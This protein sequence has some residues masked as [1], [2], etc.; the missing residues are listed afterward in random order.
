MNLDMQNI[1]S[2]RHAILL[3][4]A[5]AGAV[6]AATLEQGVFDTFNS[7]RLYDHCLD[8]SAWLPSND[9]HL[10]Y[11]N[12][13][14]R[15]CL[16]LAVTNSGNHV[17]IR[18]QW[19]TVPRDAAAF[20]QMELEFYAPAL[21]SPYPVDI[22]VK[23]NR[24]GN[25][26]KASVSVSATGW[27]TLSLPLD[28][29]KSGGLSLYWISVGGGLAD[30]GNPQLPTGSTFI[31]YF[32]E[33]R[34][35]RTDETRI[36][37]TF[38]HGA[39]WPRNVGNWAVCPY[40][41]TD[42]GDTV[43]WAN[44]PRN[45][46]G[47]MPDKPNDNGLIL[48][49]NAA[50]GTMSYAQ[51]A[52][53]TDMDLDLTS[54]TDVSFDCF[55]SGSRVP[56]SLVFYDQ[57]A[58]EGQRYA[59]TGWSNPAAMYERMQLAFPLPKAS[60]GSFNW[61][62]VD[63]IY[64]RVNTTNPYM[65]GCAWFDNLAFY[66]NSVSSLSSVGFE[67][68]GSHADGAVAHVALSLP[69]ACEYRLAERPNLLQHG[70]QGYTGPV[71]QQWTWLSPTGP[72]ELY[73]FARDSAGTLFRTSITATIEYGMLDESFKDFY[74]YFT[75]P[76]AS[77]GY[78]PYSFYPGGTHCNT[79]E[80]G[81]WA[82]SH[83]LAYDQQ[84]T[85]SPTWN[86]VR[87][88]VRGCLNQLIAWQ[89]AGLMD[90]TR[91]QYYQW[92]DA[93]GK[94]NRSTEL[95]SI[96]NAL[97]AATLLT[98]RG[99]CEQ[100]PFLKDAAMITGMCHRILQPMDYSIYYSDVTHRFSWVPNTG[101]I[102]NYSG[103]NRI[104]NAISR[105]LAVEYGTWNFTD[106]EF[107]NSVNTG[108]VQHKRSYDGVTVTATCYDGSLFTYLLP[109]Q[110]LRETETDYGWNSIDTALECQVRVMNNENRHAFGVSD[111]HGPPPN[112]RYTR[113]V[114][115]RA[116]NNP[117]I[118]PDDGVVVPGSILMS[119]ITRYRTA[120]AESLQYILTNTPQIVSSLTGYKASVSTITSALSDLY[121]EL[122][123][124][125]AMLALANINRETTWNAFFASPSVV[126]VFTA[127][128]EQVY[129]DIAPPVV[130]YDPPAAEYYEP[131]TVTLNAYDSE[132][133][134]GITNVYYTLDGTSPLTSSTRLTYT[135]PFTVDESK[136]V[137]ITAVDFAGNETEPVDAAYTI[138]PE[139]GSILTP[140]VPAMLLL[141][142][143]NR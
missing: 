84:R 88:K 64:F 12:Y 11:T 53:G 91:G 134:S 61:A 80:I 18:T 85:W 118:D 89:E 26:Q 133:G 132:T 125:H 100:R 72:A 109:A 69:G 1:T 78:L 13:D 86:E 87:A 130:W 143:Y 20:D 94:T 117:Y 139:P 124:G 32:D 82:L 62:D 107:R 123:D 111:S 122:D 41:W 51:L 28:Y 14:G 2:F 113:G 46:W 34:L 98:I 129:Q 70:W 49:Y 3:L 54:I 126:N 50:A 56:V 97:L 121:S 110:F 24:D 131:V 43:D 135:A 59:A 105:M 76:L 138:I 19:F 60:S 99:Y 33:L 77:S 93:V 141:R 40:E 44:M 112:R 65:N 52:P 7:M 119:C 66:T 103:E 73:L 45:A 79:T 63:N 75:Y 101:G 136:T 57:D 15:S 120:A 108:L 92:Y 68:A 47:A 9:R 22:I 58:P 17:F 116:S 25:E 16:A 48:P 95:P 5:I 10:A 29:N 74:S 55:R 30:W 106:D 38:E 23:D 39:Y 102:D 128:Y 115:P 21:S 71:T 137:R 36:I 6:C 114:P 8:E 96:D 81:L 27:H 35:A 31:V 83:V 104:I 90:T 4:G 142:K 67:I 42:S 127:W 140:M 37:D